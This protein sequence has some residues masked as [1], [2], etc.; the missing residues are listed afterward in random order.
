[1][2]SMP[3]RNPYATHRDRFANSQRV[4]YSE[5]EEEIFSQNM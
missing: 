2:K 4:R 3:L 1:M 5:C